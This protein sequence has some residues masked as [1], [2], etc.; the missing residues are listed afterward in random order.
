MYV[1]RTVIYCRISQDATGAGLGVQ[2]QEKDC[3]ALCRKRGWRVADVVVENDT[4]A[5][6]KKRR[7]LYEALL[8]RIEAD[9]L[10]KFGQARILPFTMD[11]R[12]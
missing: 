7:K 11:R 3:R 6:G 4:S 9:V 12:S 8:D 5:Y 10:E 2:R 1:M